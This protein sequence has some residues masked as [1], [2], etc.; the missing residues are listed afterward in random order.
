MRL[1]GNETRHSQRLPHLHIARVFAVENNR[2]Q[3]LAIATSD[4]AYAGRP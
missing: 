4:V 1:F 3:A 2:G